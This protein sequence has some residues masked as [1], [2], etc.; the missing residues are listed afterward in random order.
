LLGAVLHVG[1]PVAYD[2]ISNA[3]IFEIPIKRVV[4][5]E[6]GFHDDV[7]AEKPDENGTYVESRLWVIRIRCEACTSV[8]CALGSLF[9]HVDALS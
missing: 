8:R 5:S 9:G 7:E 3:R 1:W 6:E 4:T 2:R